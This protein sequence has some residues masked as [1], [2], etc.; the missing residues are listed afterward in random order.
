METK[1]TFPIKGMHCASCVTLLEDSLNKLDGV[2]KATVNLAT[3]K[4]TVSYDSEKVT[5]QHLAGAVSNVGYK[6]LIGGEQRHEADEKAEKQK[7]LKDLKIKVII[8]LCLGGLIF[9]GSFPGLMNTAPK[10]LQNFWLQMMLSVPVQFW[11]G[12]SF[13][14]ATV[15]ALKHRT[16]NMDTLV[17]I[18]TTV[19]FGYSVFVT[20]LPQLVESIGID[21]MPYFD[22]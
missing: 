11:A 22:V 17:A 19:A 14:R 21:P 10:I 5:D 1:K 3:E 13:Y 20:T 9:W 12:W 8:S 7:E 15:L 18:G 6:A 4:A 16:A 2:L